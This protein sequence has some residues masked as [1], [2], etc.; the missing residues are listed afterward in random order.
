MPQMTRRWEQAGNGRPDEVE[1]HLLLPW[2]EVLLVHHLDS[3][4]RDT[5]LVDNGCGIQNAVKHAA[6]LQQ[7]AAVASQ[8]TV[9]AVPPGDMLV[10]VWVDRLGHDAQ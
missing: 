4:A 5:P 6:G 1:P 10:T 2:R 3:G 8:Q 9:L 7:G